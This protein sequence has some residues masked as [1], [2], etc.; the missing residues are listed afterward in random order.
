MYGS[1]FTF[2]RTHKHLVYGNS[3]PQL[4]STDSAIR[5]RIKIVPFKVSFR[6]REDKDLPRRLREEMGFV[7]QWLIVGT[8]SGWQPVS[9]SPSALRWTQRAPITLRRSQPRRCG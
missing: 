8:R 1:S 2:Q 3:R 6:G 7:L 9:A 5:S 4:R